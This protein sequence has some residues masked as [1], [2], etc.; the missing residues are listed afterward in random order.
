MS[1]FIT[2]GTLLAL[3]WADQWALNRTPTAPDLTEL[4]MQRRESILIWCVKMSLDGSG[5]YRSLG[6]GMLSALGKACLLRR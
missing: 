6:Q 5:I 4:P 3:Q 2:F 1:I